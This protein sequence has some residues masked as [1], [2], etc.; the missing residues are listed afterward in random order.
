MQELAY[1]VLL[2]FMF[3]TFSNIPFIDIPVFII[4]IPG[5]EVNKNVPVTDQESVSPT[6]IWNKR[7]I[8]GDDYATRSLQSTP[9]HD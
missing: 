5:T 4:T 6:N 3:L 7:K 2:L 9:L 8:Q 1:S